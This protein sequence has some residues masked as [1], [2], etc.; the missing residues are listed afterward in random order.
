M[1]TE[2]EAHEKAVRFRPVFLKRR[3]EIY[4]IFTDYNLVSSDELIKSIKDELEGIFLEFAF[5]P[6][7]KTK[8][9]II[10][11]QISHLI[12]LLISLA[13]KKETQKKAVNLLSKS[14]KDLELLNKNM[15]KII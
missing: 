2:I 14:A 4:K 11:I 7:T 5:A 6:I 12:K 1:A 8:V 9:E 13:N 15:K 10:N 3:G